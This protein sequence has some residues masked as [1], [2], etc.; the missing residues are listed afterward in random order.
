MPLVPQQKRQVGAILHKRRSN[1]ITVMIV[2]V[3]MAVVDFTM[4]VPDR[5]WVV[6]ATMKAKAIPRLNLVVVVLAVS[7]AVVMRVDR[8]VKQ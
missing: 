2:V 1:P 7:V 4:E 3:V 6:P 5:G 8:R